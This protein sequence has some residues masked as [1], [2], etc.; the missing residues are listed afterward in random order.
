MPFPG[1]GTVA[2]FWYNGFLILWN[3][4]L[5]DA[6]FTAKNKYPTY[7]LWVTGGS[8]GGCL[9][10]NA[11][12][13]ISQMGFMD[14]SQIK[15]VSFGQTRVGDAVFAERY[16]NLVPYAYRVT[17]RNDIAPHLVPYEAGYRHFKNEVSNKHYL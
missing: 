9:A 5:R 4:G 3:G 14:K 6:F 17:H 10:S 15:M 8:M 7:E 13:Y 16:P 12:A 11:A 1:G 2:K